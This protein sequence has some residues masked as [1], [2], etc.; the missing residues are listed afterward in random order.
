MSILGPSRNLD[1]NNIVLPFYNSHFPLHLLFQF[2][3]NSSLSL[4]LPS[5]QSGKKP[6]LSPKMAPPFIF[7]QNLQDLEEEYDDG[8]LSVQN[9]TAISSFRPSSLEEF[10]KGVSFDLSDKELFCVEDQDL[11]DRVYSLVKDF[12]NLTPACKFNLV[13]SLRSNFSVLLPNVDSLSRASQSRDDDEPPVH[14]RI[15]SHRNAFKIYTFFLVHVIL[16]EESNSTSNNTTKVKYFFLS[17]SLYIWFCYFMPVSEFWRVFENG[18][19]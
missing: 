19:R 13:E 12:S 10:V 16:A 3:F 11:F 7:P 4:S 9:H 1:P 14:D 2:H 17:L 5:Y 15:A 18:F 6:N 8:R